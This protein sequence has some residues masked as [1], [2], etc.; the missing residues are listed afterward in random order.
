MDSA[1]LSDWLQVTGL[2]GVIVSLV[3]VGLEIQQSR[4][5]AIADIY[6]QRAEMIV[7]VNSIPLTS[8]ILHETRSKLESGEALTNTEQSLLDQSWNP[9]F[10][11]VENNHFQ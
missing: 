6:Q 1:K 8:E 4:Q 9:Y 5:I 2:F 11:Y 7:Q 10:N 3:F